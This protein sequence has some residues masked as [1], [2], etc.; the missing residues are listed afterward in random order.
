VKGKAIVKFQYL[1][2]VEGDL[3]FFK[4]HIRQSEILHFTNKDEDQLEFNNDNSDELFIFGGDV[5]DRGD[6]ITITEMLV[7]LKEAHPHRVILIVGNRDA[8]KTRFSTEL[9]LSPYEK[10]DDEVGA[11]ALPHGATITYQKFLESLDGGPIN[12]PVNRL[13]W[14]LSCTM[15]A[16]TAFECRRQELLRLRNCA[17]VNDEEVYLSFRQSIEPGGFMRK[18]LSLAQI[19]AIIG[20]TL[21]VHGGVCAAN[22]GKVPNAFVAFEKTLFNSGRLFQNAEPDMV[23]YD[24]V[25]QWIDQLNVWYQSAIDRWVN[26]PID[27]HPYQY[28]NL[29]P[30]SPLQHIA[31]SQ[32]SYFGNQLPVVGSFLNEHGPSPVD[33]KV[34]VFLQKAG[35]NRILAGHQPN[36]GMPLALFGSNKSPIQAGSLQVFTCDTLYG[37]R[38]AYNS[39]SGAQVR[40]T[41]PRGSSYAVVHITCDRQLMSSSTSIK[42]VDGFEVGYET[43]INFPRN[44]FEDPFMGRVV[45]IGDKYYTVRV[46]HSGISERPYVLT[47]TEGYVV[48]CIHLSAVELL[49]HERE[50]NFLT[51]CK[52]SSPCNTQE[53]L[54]NLLKK[55]ELIIFDVDGTILRDTHIQYWKHLNLASAKFA[56]K[57]WS[58]AQF[59]EYLKRPHG[60]VSRQHIMATMLGHHP[61]EESELVKNAIEFFYQSFNLDKQASATFPHV[62]AAIAQLK[63]HGI[64]SIAF[65]DTEAVLVK[66]MLS[67]HDLHVE[68]ESIV[69]TAKKPDV[70]ILCDTLKERAAKP[71]LPGDNVLVIGDNLKADGALAKKAG[72]SFLY[73]SGGDQKKAKDFLLA[74]AAASIP[75]GS[76]MVNSHAEVVYILNALLHAQSENTYGV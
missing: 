8:N 41:N 43:V 21:V 2:D 46:N 75:E 76:Y 71:Q 3:Q 1:T 7:K 64:P 48:S 62:I 66:K 10:L 65:S 63:N 16:Q 74:K 53:D 14:I 56:N 69:G 27:S 55:V 5:C 52:I 6:D 70:T 22:I 38:D 44:Q 59:W 4:K 58:N 23:E 40:A 26:A 15:G 49:E 9:P 50:G 25:I 31:I 34:A 73:F 72:C 42:G 12:T 61:D 18:Y 37:N 11:V 57:E 19:G 51:E 68:F 28:S 67:D 13:K 17:L 20:D 60:Y 54:K 24:E 33:E 30:A 35:V 36:S 47:T 32:G 39:V 29:V 45:L